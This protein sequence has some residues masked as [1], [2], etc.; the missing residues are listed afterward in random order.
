MLCTIEQPTGMKTMMI[1]IPYDFCLETEK[2]YK[3]KGQNE[4]ALSLNLFE[5]KVRVFFK[6]Y[7]DIFIKK[8]LYFGYKNSQQNSR[9]MPFL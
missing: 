7:D 6:V 1:A 3:V 8:V 5:H 9:S 2:R 4:V